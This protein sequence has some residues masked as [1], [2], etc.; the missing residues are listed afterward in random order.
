VSIDAPLF[1][2]I[3]IFG[4]LGMARGLV[5]QAWGLAVLVALVTLRPW[6]LEPAQA[7]LSQAVPG[8][9]P[10]SQALRALLGFVVLYLGLTG[11]GWAVERL[12]VRKTAVVNEVDRILG[13]AFGLAK[14]GVLAILLT[15]CLESALL[16]GV[17]VDDPPVDMLEASVAVGLASATN[18]WKVSAL[19]RVLAEVERTRDPAATDPPAMPRRARNLAAHG[20]LPELLEARR[21][22]GAEWPRWRHVM[23]T[24]W[25]RHDLARADVSQDLLSRINPAPGP[26]TEAP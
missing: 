9:L 11:A 6:N 22:Q 3:A 15:W 18:P 19:R 24:A 10:G 12:F 21:E 26:P 23:D 17:T 5:K 25:L 4:G 8:E 16:K 14:G 7:L 1:V 13:L 2:M 20:R